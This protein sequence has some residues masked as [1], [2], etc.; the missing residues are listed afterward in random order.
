VG[1]AGAGD[2][3]RDPG[4]LAE[5]SHEPLDST[6]GEA[7]AE[8]RDERA[9]RLRRYPVTREIDIPNNDDDSNNDVAGAC[10]Q[11]LQL[12]WK[13]DVMVCATAHLLE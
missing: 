12:I 10:D 11:L 8:V 4:G 2:R 1:G 13:A 9:R 3:A 5:G 6:D 7:L